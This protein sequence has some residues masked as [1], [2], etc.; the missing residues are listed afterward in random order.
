MTAGTREVADTVE[1]LLRGDGYRKLDRLIEPVAAARIRTRVMDHLDDGET[2]DGG[3][4]YV[5]GLGDRSEEF[6]DLVSHPRLLAVTK[7]LLGVEVGLAGFSASV[8]MPG[9]EL[10]PLH[11]DYPYW[12]VPPSTP[13]DPALMMQVIWL[14][15]PFNEENGGTWVAP[16]S[17]AWVGR[18]E[19]ERFEASAVQVTGGAGDAIVSHG[20]L[21]HRTAVNHSATPRVAILIN[22][23][24]LAV[25]P[26]PGGPFD[27]ESLRRA[28]PDLGELLG[29]L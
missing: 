6:R 3:A 13:V 29:R 2:H 1:A 26:I 28:A 27:D 9:C 11:V 18:P 21:W 19:L 25:R 10:G 17:Q 24:Q 20:S 16:G 14:M 7:E 22:Y 15:E 5:R 12:A 23:M 4:I 8:L